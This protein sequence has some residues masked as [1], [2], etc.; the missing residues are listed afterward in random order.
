MTEFSTIARPYAEAAFKR[1]LET[2]QIDQWSDQLAVLSAMVSD[3]QMRE[4]LDDATQRVEDRVGLVFDVCP[5]EL[6]DEVKNFVNILAENDRLTVLPEIE[7]NYNAIKV[8][9]NGM[10][11]VE[12]VS[13][14]AVSESQ[15]QLLVKAL[16]KRLG[17]KINISSREDA[18][19][20][21]GVII[22]AGDLVIDGS[23]RG[24][25]GQMTT[26]LGI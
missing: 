2:D 20:I 13:A 3:S 4:V 22:K 1:A 19:L 25:L 11:D 23:I 26:E 17:K 8:D 5:D 15:E 21:G 12:V 10:I 24:K 6:I 14:Y 16:E 7:S 9:H 18:D